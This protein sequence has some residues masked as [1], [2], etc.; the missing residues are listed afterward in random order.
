MKF[1]KA[2]SGA[3]I[4]GIIFAGMSLT[5]SA[6]EVSKDVIS[7]DG[8]TF[9]VS[10]ANENEDAGYL[11]YRHN[12][13]NERMA[14]NSPAGRIKENLSTI[15]GTF[16]SY[17]SHDSRFDGMDR[18]YLIDV[19]QWQGK[20]DWQ[21]VKKDG[22][23][24]VI[25]RL[26]YRG[27]GSAGTLMMDNSFYENIKG[28]KAAGLKVGIYFYTQAI[29]Y[30]EARQEADFCAE[31][32]KGFDIDLPVYYDIES[33]DF[34]YGRLDHAGLTKAQKTKLCKEFC[35][36]IESYGY[37]SGVYANYYW[38]TNMIN[39]PE[40]GNDYKTWVA[41]YGSYLNYGGIYDMWQ[42]SSNADIDGIKGSVDINVMYDVDYSPTSTVKVNIDNGVLSW[43]KAA[44][45]D[46]YTVYGSDNGTDTYVVAD[47]TG[48]SFDINGQSSGKYCVAA[49]NYF[50]GKKHYGKTSNMVDSFRQA[51]E[52]V[53]ATRIGIDK[54][55][56]SWNAVPEAVGYE[57]YTVTDG[58]SMLV[59]KTSDT[60]LEIRGS[61]L[62]KK[63]VVVRAYNKNGLFGDLSE[64]V[65]LPG[66]APSDVPYAEFRANRLVWT[67]V[68]DADGYIITRYLNGK[69]SEL[70]VQENNYYVDDSQSA[71]FYVQAYIELEGQ[72]FRTEHSNICSFN[73]VNYPPKGS[74]ELDSSADGLTWNKIDDAVGY[75]VYKLDYDGS[76]VEVGRVDGCHFSTEDTEA[77][78]FYVKGYNVKDGQEFYTEASN[79][80]IISLPEV[81]EAALVSKTD[82]Y[83]VISWN[84]IDGCDEYMVYLDKGKGYELYSTVRGRKAMI[85]DLKDADFASVRIKGYIGNK[86]VVSYGLFSN[87]LYIIGDENSRPAK[88]VFDF[89]DL[90]G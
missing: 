21:K 28:A 45:A 89:G 17:L 30:A 13:I 2:A 5:A 18:T 36:R 84:E 8:E 41:A 66:N 26:G 34:D 11:K 3:V 85:G 80:V 77:I 76:E 9:E 33:V 12:L 16:G 4:A 23:N 40:L 10:Y 83:A 61:D 20:I 58:K 42:Y 78:E 63:K 62:Q 74:I 48:T 55:S 37:E 52:N 69:V 24:D 70:V 71:E 60:F 31:A 44:G 87:Q 53:E 39:G 67:V 14:R 6:D 46:G 43:N 73:G 27:Y 88:E 38:L 47:V 29:S 32:L 79:R 22:I 25:I 7:A 51:P 49:Y 50:S 15:C 56:V 75:V 82:D 86:D 57:V 59:G 54:V 1:I 65:A 68:P 64:Q 90:L 72:K 35:N 19:S 81:T